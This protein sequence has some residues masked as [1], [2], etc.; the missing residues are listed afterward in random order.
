MWKAQPSAQM[1]AQMI[2][3][4]KLLSICEPLGALAMFA[5]LLVQP[6]ALGF[7]LVMLGAIHLKRSKMKVPFKSDTSTGWEFDLLI[8]AASLLLLT[9]GA[10][11][12]SLDRLILGL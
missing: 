5:G 9:I 12:I 11:A 3:V 6:A 4:M 1:P 7:S 10:G 2:G 8:L